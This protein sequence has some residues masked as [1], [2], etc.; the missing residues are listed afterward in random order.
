MKLKAKVEHLI[1]QLKFIVRMASDAVHIDSLKDGI[2]LISRSG[3]DVVEAIIH[4]QV[5]HPSQ[6]QVAVQKTGLK[7]LV[8]GIQSWGNRG[9]AGKLA[10]LHFSPDQLKAST[11]QQPASQTS[12]PVSSQSETIK[13]PA[14]WDYRVITHW[15]P[16]G[17]GTLK[18][19]IHKPPT[20]SPEKGVTRLIIDPA[21]IH[22]LSYNGHILAEHHLPAHADGRIQIDV[23]NVFL[24][25][26]LDA[27]FL[28]EGM[29]ELSR[30]QD[31]VKLSKDWRTLVTP[32]V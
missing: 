7:F 12:L 31:L 5:S 28:R 1:A 4:A 22:I 25:K 20:R 19:L 16:D 13:I 27:G 11:Q 17:L 30:T 9:S 29:L 15:P 2:S 23:A 3:H 10:H 6:V 14:S 18:D 32:I 24:R 21:G 26:A 8:K